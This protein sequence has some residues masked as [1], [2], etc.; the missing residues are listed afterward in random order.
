LGQLL[1]R[2]DSGVWD[3]DLI[4]GRSGVEV[5][6]STDMTEKGSWASNDPAIRELSEGERRAAMLREGDIVITKA[7]GS[8]RHLGKAALVDGGMA[9]RGVAFSNFMQRIRPRPELMSRY[10]WYFLNSSPGREQLLYLGTTTT[11]LANLNASIIGA[12][13]IPLPPLRE[14][15]D[16]VDGLD[17]GMGEVDRLSGRVTAHIR[18]LRERRSASIT[19]AVTG[20]L[21]IRSVA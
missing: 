9:A 1:L 16:V 19:A 8:R 18:L 4:A 7:S 13:S 14:Q 11:G 2:N 5:V 3:E 20:Q 6:R 15:R 21:D 10:L 17:A 12:I